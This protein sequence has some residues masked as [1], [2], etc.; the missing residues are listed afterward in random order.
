MRGPP[1]EV[2]N[3]DDTTISQMRWWTKA[4]VIA[5]EG[6]KI[7]N[8]YTY[9]PRIFLEMFPDAS[10]GLNGPLAGAGSCFLTSSCQPWVYLNWPPMIRFNTPN[11]YQVTF[12]HKM[13]TLE[14]F[15]ALMGLVSEPDL[16]RNKSSIII[17]SCSSGSSLAF[18]L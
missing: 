17:G 18:R 16:I 1:F 11:S 7:P 10:G 12:A 8:P 14:A 5:K 4:I 13:S 9:T 3:L 6:S 2:I 15:A